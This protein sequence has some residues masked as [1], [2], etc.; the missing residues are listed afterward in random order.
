MNPTDTTHG[1]RGSKR[2]GRQTVRHHVLD[3]MN[4]QTLTCTRW[5]V[6]TL[7]VVERYVDNMSETKLNTAKKFNVKRGSS[8]NTKLGLCWS[9][10]GTDT[11]QW[12]NPYI[13]LVLKTF[14]DFLRPDH[15]MMNKDELR[16]AIQDKLAIIL[17]IIN[18]VTARLCTALTNNVHNI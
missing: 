10:N 6:T 14:K 18:T 3:N 8:Q 11:K 13:S 12:Y 16:N 7:F 5:L 9:T 1:I 17:L 2:M 15:A 4:H